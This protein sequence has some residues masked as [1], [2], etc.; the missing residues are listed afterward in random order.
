MTAPSV[1]VT[2]GQILDPNRE[3]MLAAREI[4]DD[5]EAVEGLT[6]WVERQPA[7]VQ[8]YSE[9]NQAMLFV[10]IMERGLGR[11]F[12]FTRLQ[13]FNGWLPLGRCVSKGNKGF[14][15]SSIISSKVKD[16]DGNRKV[17]EN[18][19]PEKA[20]RVKYRW[21]HLFD[22]SQTAVLPVE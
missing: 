15:M 14:V 3:I 20:R 5:E 16:E 2:A 6:R 22:E 17:D 13:A 8:A 10:Q 11:K 1:E 9:L 21:I 4:L 12:K 7:Q 18:G 19:D